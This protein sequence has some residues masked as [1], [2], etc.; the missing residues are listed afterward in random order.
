VYAIV[1]SGGK[2]YRVEPGATIR[3]ERLAGPVGEQVTLADVLFL[4]GGERPR[5][6]SPRLDNVAVVGTILEHGRGEK[7][8]VFKYKKRKHYRRTRGHRQDYTALRI[9]RIEA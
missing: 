3:V 5:A 9:E 2:Q 1:R 8:R 7:V 6:G 4:G